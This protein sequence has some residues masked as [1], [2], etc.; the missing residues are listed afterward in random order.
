MTW[1][2]KTVKL[3]TGITGSC[4]RLPLYNQN[5]SN[6]KSAKQS[7]PEIYINTQFYSIDLLPSTDGEIKMV[8]LH[9]RFESGTA[10]DTKGFSREHCYKRVSMGILQI[11]R[12]GESEDKAGYTDCSSSLKF[13]QPNRLHRTNPDF[14]TT[15]SLTWRHTAVIHT[16]ILT[17]CLAEPDKTSEQLLQT[18]STLSFCQICTGSFHSWSLLQE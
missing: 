11:S 6:N 1:K 9:L 13:K 10:W 3:L 17:A 15:I 2:N 5:D 14:Q 12:Q 4:D 16:C 18:L 7:T 8:L